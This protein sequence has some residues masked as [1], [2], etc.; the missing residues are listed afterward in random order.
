MEDSRVYGIDQ[1]ANQLSHTEEYV[2]PTGIRLPSDASSSGG[3]MDDGHI[4]KISE[5]LGAPSFDGFDSLADEDKLE[6]HPDRQDAIRGT[7]IPDRPRPRPRRRTSPEEEAWESQ[8]RPATPPSPVFGNDSGIPTLSEADLHPKRGIRD[9]LVTC[10]SF[11]VGTSEACSEHYTETGDY[12]NNSRQ[13]MDLYDAEW[14][15][16]FDDYGRVQGRPLYSSHVSEER[17]SYPSRATPMLIGENLPHTDFGETSSYR[18]EHLDFDDRESVSAS[19]TTVSF[20]ATSPRVATPATPRSLAIAD[21]GELDG[22]WRT[23]NG[24]WRTVDLGWLQD[25]P[26]DFRD[27]RLSCAG[28]E[29]TRCAWD[30]ITWASGLEQVEWRRP[31]PEELDGPWLSAQR[32]YR[33]IEGGMLDGEEA[34]T[35]GEGSVWLNSWKA[36]SMTDA[37][38]TWKSAGQA[39]MWHRPTADDL[40]GPWL[41]KLD[42]QSSASFLR[43]QH[44]KSGH[45]RGASAGSRTALT[46]RGGRLSFGGWVI[47]NLAEESVVWSSGDG[48]RVEW[49]RPTPEFLEGAWFVEGAEGGWTSVV[50]G[51][52]PT[53]QIRLTRGRLTHQGWVVTDMDEDHIVWEQCSPSAPSDGTAQPARGASSAPANET[54][55]GGPR[56]QH[57]IEAL[58]APFGRLVSGSDDGLQLAIVW[59][60]PAL[61]DFEGPWFSEKRRWQVVKHGVLEGGE[62]L[63]KRDGNVWRGAWKVA[64]HDQNFVK[65]ETV[66]ETDVWHRPPPDILEGPWLVAAAGDAGS[67][68]DYAWRNVSSGCVSEAAPGVFSPLSNARPAGGPVALE[69]GR[70]VRGGWVVV[71]LSDDC[72]RWEH[73]DLGEVRWWRPAARDLDGP[74]SN[75]EGR[76]RNIEGGKL[77]DAPLDLQDGRLIYSGWLL[78]HATEGSLRWEKDGWPSLTWRRPKPQDLD[79]PWL[80]KEDGWRAVLNGKLQDVPIEESGGRLYFNGWVATALTELTLRWQCEGHTVEWHRP[81]RPAGRGGEAP[82]LRAL[83]VTPPPASRGALT[84]SSAKGVAARQGPACGSAFA[85]VAARRRRGGRGS[86]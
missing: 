41:N 2:S 15:Q 52:L 71:E 44:V 28:W 33:N 1:M 46:S 50:G 81:S 5:H 13:E 53:G 62:L 43:W 85:A 18:S 7:V 75:S 40:E 58:D 17:T 42:L 68:G 37:S 80:S 78:A 9:R 54:S 47:T 10:A 83:V 4:S 29:A 45:V 56:G 79:G 24:E 32:M 67:Q 55:F 25:R 14:R 12:A 86:N 20:G 73:P 82:P 49:R 21:I 51:E 36:V 39:K 57:V 6:Q 59:R 8:A 70:L 72:V 34:L 66:G 35:C 76:W 69:G 65:W 3:R 27:G 19:T 63:S 31:V 30:F 48:E 64:A 38:V 60:R 84:P 22:V 74:W 23:S 16:N 26:L 61:G 11:G 77:P